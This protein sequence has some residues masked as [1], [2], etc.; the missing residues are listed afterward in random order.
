MTHIVT[1]T[2]GALLAST[3]PGSSDEPLSEDQAKARC[4][5][6][7]KEAEKLRIKTRYEVREA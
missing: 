1:T 5:R 7:N 3:V 4:Q 6:A 2:E